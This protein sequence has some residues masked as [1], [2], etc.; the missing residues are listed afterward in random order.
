MQASP[1]RYLESLLIELD[2][3]IENQERYKDQKESYIRQLQ[4]RLTLDNLTP[5]ERYD[6]YC[7]LTNEF[8]FYRCDSARFYA[9][10]QL[11]LAEASGKKAWETD[12]KIKL[13][14]ILSKAAL[15]IEAISLLDSISPE[16]LS[17][18]QKIAYYSSYYETYVSWGDFLSNGFEKTEVYEK[19][20]FFHEKY[21]ELLPMSSYE[22]AAYYGIKYITDNQPEKAEQ[23]L[24]TSL[25]QS[26]PNTRPYSILTSVL[27]FLYTTKGDME[28]TKEYLALSAISD[29]RGNI[30]ENAS[31]RELATYLFDENQINRAN[32]YI[33]KSMEDANF[34][35]SRIRNYQTSQILPIIDRAYQ[36]DRA[37]QQKQLERS[38]LI[39][40]V[41]SVILLTGIFFIFSE[42]RKVSAAKKKISDINEQLQINN[43][44]LTDINRTLT[45]T[46]HIKEEYIGHFLGLCSVY[47]EKMERYRKKLLTQAKTGKPEE[48]YKMIRSTQ[49]IEDERTEFYTT[50]DESFLELFPDFVERF[51]A[52]LPED[53]KVILKPN[54]KLTT[55]LRIF[56]LIRLGITDSA[57]IAEFLNYSLATIY[58]Y[59][60]RY[61]NKAIVPR[62]EFEQEILKIGTNKQ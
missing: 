21:I 13:A 50:F 41:L 42:I 11:S 17:D 23:L 34:Y 22:Y 35:N 8:E 37:R 18:I 6:T 46:D 26:Q 10:Q 2:R 7:R 14:F 57:K 62:D 27:S 20:D 61:R 19:R 29:I 40:S 30:M 25:P 16:E 45:E 38:L 48:L 36:Q 12:S 31:L 55:G 51:N 53:E 59:R 47:I 52:L 4:G 1:D 32:T 60:S 5:E 54:E 44:A 15:F 39:I 49:F 33:K 56:A 58:N 9:L 3:A 24:L 28:K 43:M